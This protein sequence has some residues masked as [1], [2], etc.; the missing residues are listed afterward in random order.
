[1]ENK[2][3][4]WHPA[5]CSTLQIELEGEPLQFLIEHNLTR[6]PLQ[7]DLLVIKKT[8][9]R[10]IQKNIGR[11]F[12]KH[13]IVE[14]KSPEDYFSINDYYKVL[15]YAGIYQSNT[16]KVMEILPED[17]TIS[18]VTNHYPKKMVAYLERLYEIDVKTV[19][20]GIYYLVGLP[21]PTQVIVIKQLSR[22]ENLWLSRLR[23]GL[24][25]KEDLEVLMEA[26]KGKQEN[27]LYSASMDVIM[28]A[29]QENYE[30]ELGMCDAIME[31][32][33][34]K[35]DERERMGELRGVLQGEQKGRALQSIELI[36]KK[37]K[38]QKSEEEIAED[39]EG[40]L[41]EIRSICQI[42][43]Q[44]APEYPVEDIYKK[45]KEELC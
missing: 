26:Y 41:D 42:A 27:P 34:D 19:F 7:I 4:Q 5:F 39:L 40:E 12:R 11:I 36:C 44:F 24:K 43:R 31:L 21:F 10:E 32:V 35:L 25:M 17:I 1:M 14:F 3:L 13:N 18:F 45:W 23:T 20:P 2:P 33:A 28:R 29:N 38:K 9:G 6:K 16:E 15:G 30:E 22:Q 37:L 8:D